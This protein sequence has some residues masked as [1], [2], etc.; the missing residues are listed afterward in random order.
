MAEGTGWD[1]AGLHALTGGNP[2]FVTEVLAAAPGE[3]PVSVADAVLTRVRKLG[4]GCQRALAQLA[5]VPGT[6]E[7]GLAETLLAGELELLTEAEEHGILQV[8]AGGVAFRHELARQAIEQG[9]PLLRRRALHHNV[10]T[11]LRAGPAPD[12]AR[13]V[14]HA[15]QAGD[16]ETVLEFAVRAGRESAAAGSHRQALAHFEAAV[17]HA[18]RLDPPHRAALLDDY[19][20]ELHNAHRFGEALHAS[21]QAVALYSEL[22]EPLALGESRVRLSRLYY[23]AGDTEHAETVARAAVEVVEPAGS[24]EVT[25]Y[26]TA[27]HAA[28]LALSGDPRADETLRRAAGLAAGCG[29]VDL[30]ELCLNYQAQAQP[31]L[32]AG[33]RVGLLRQ[34]LALALEHGHYEHAA[35]GYTNLGELLYRYGRFAELEQCLAAGLTFTRERGF[36]SHTYNLEVHHNLLRLRRGDWTGAGEG[37]AGLVERAEDSGMLRVYAE[38]HHARLL[39]RRGEPGAAALVQAAW[40]R[41]CGQG[42]LP[43]L[44]FAATAFMEWAWLQDRPDLAEALLEQWKQYAGRPGI[45]PVTAELSR[46]AARAGVLVAADSGLPEPW[47]A[48]IR[49]DWR[50]AVRGWEAAGDPYERALELAASGE[51]DQTMEALSVLDDLGA[52]EV[53]RRA[54]RRLKGLGVRA[55]PRRPVA[56]TRAHPA[57][58]T[59]RQADV[60]DLVAAGLTNAEIADRLVVSVRTVD[61]HVSTILGK[62]G[63]SSRREAGRLALTYA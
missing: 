8:A 15:A 35:R 23:L 59:A 7:F 29:R 47:L 51:V 2:F 49:G 17:H 4:D 5:V 42:S 57:G 3:V 54:R 37:F 11:A 50:A 19:A 6:V 10:L 30:T 16:A 22:P 41:A 24:P 27:Y 45:E 14:H 46:Y 18:D 26:A 36:W 39:A 33:E 9:T 44:G 52:V 1:P 38:P 60:L 20:W 21:E 31:G 13:L 53:A 28:I 55:V 48:G 43:G 63:V 40:Q 62:L 56:A 34:S 12:L 32:A 58:L 61:H 25:A